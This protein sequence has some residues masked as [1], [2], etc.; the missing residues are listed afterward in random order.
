MQTILGLLGCITFIP[1]PA[2][3]AGIQTFIF[4]LYKYFQNTS[5]FLRFFMSRQL[6]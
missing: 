1:F 5:I 2:K 3:V 4:A 6:F